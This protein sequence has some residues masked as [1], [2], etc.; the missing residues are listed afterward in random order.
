M[1]RIKSIVL[2]AQNEVRSIADA[3]IYTEMEDQLGEIIS[4]MEPLIK[5]NTSEDHSYYCLV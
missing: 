2:Y 1:E 3:H 5:L 4:G